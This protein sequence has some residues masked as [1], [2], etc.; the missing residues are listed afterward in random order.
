MRRRQIIKRKASLIPKI[1]KIG[2][3]VLVLLLILD[4]Y[5]L[6]DSRIFNIKNLEV[7]LDKINCA[8]EAN[9]RQDS[10]ILGKNILLLKSQDIEKKLKS[11]FFCIKNIN[12]SR[13]FPGKVKIEVSGREPVAVLAL[14][15]NDEA[16]PSAE[17]DYLA[18]NSA[19]ITPKEE[20][21][22][23]FL[24]DSDGVVFSK[25]Q[26]NVN[27]PVLYFRGSNLEIGKIVGETL[28]E[29]T[30]KILQTIKRC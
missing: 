8:S 29:N 13:Q 4:A 30:L 14:L 22:D 2:T 18:S 10:G 5:L 3:C 15:K 28:I 23:Q 26:G 1:W 7:K 19:T 24:V 12:L 6:F 20:V 16:S 11:N 27:L 17:L 21:S 9:I 25:L